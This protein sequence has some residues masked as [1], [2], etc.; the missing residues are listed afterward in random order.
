MKYPERVIEV[1][2]DV[3]KDRLF[4]VKL[5]MTAEHRGDFLKDLTEV[6][7]RLNINILNLDLKHVESL[8]HINVEIEVKNLNH[9][10]QITRTIRKISGVI[11]VE[12]VS[13]AESSM[14][15]LEE[16]G[17]EIKYKKNV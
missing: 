8:I 9:L 3:D 12:R 16:T 1:E 10:N 7:A 2:W 13:G 4:S 6:L 14:M 11:L 15:K 17:S 5:Y